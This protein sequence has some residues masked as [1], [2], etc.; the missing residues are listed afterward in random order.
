MQVEPDSHSLLDLLSGPPALA[1]PPAALSNSSFTGTPDP[2]SGSASSQQPAFSSFP[3]L[4]LPLREVDGNGDGDVDISDRKTPLRFARTTPRAPRVAALEEEEDESD[5]DDDDGDD[6]DD[7][8]V[9]RNFGYLNELLLDT[10]NT[11]KTQV[12]A[13]IAAAV[14]EADDV[15]GVSVAASA[16]APAPRTNTKGVVTA[17]TDTALDVSTKDN[18][19]LCAM[20]DAFMKIDLKGSV[21]ESRLL[22]E[23]HQDERTRARKPID[24]FTHE[25]AVEEA[26]LASCPQLDIEIKTACLA[27]NGDA[28][29]VSH[30]K[31]FDVRTFIDTLSVSWKT[32]NMAVSAFSAT[33]RQVIIRDGKVE[34]TAGD[35]HSI[36]LPA[37]DTTNKK[38]SRNIV[39]AAEEQLNSDAVA[40]ALASRIAVMQGMGLLPE[41]KGFD[42]NVVSKRICP[43]LEELNTA[44]RASGICFDAA[45]IKPPYVHCLAYNYRELTFQQAHAILNT[46][47]K[48]GFNRDCV[49]LLA[50]TGDNPFIGLYLTL[51]DIVK[52]SQHLVQPKQHEAAA[53]QQRKRKPKQ[54]T[55]Q[56][57]PRT[58]GDADVEFTA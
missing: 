25:E 46:A 31:P 28:F 43:L 18:D 19:A 13:A 53:E 52:R 6:T 30:S 2:W 45:G 10:G 1:L 47:D 9:V 50:Q 12:D 4:A 56:A 27:L 3:R 49:V 54:S 36:A 24:Q 51:A 23:E 58:N 22:L 39:S 35:A 44:L 37:R 42:H 32:V 17:A 8:E 48:H 16:T 40:D 15:K 5:D 55:Q 21:S 20:L 14:A 7:V 26:I 38:R 33:E 57:G 41:T 11:D 34:T 29:T